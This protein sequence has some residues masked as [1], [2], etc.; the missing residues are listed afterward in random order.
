LLEPADG[1]SFKKVGNGLYA[2]KE[3]N[4]YDG[5]GLLLGPQ[6]PFKNIP[7]LGIE[8]KYYKTVK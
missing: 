3:G 7:I 5:K 2:S 1:E 4:I 8:F 6:C